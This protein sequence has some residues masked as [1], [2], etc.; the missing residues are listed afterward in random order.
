M[1]L[2]QA[3]K[4]KLIPAQEEDVNDEG[5]SFVCYLANIHKD[6]ITTPRVMLKMRNLGVG[7]IWRWVYVRR[8]DDYRWEIYET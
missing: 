4:L 7:E 2:G 5:V 3:M 1:W 6:L 8:R